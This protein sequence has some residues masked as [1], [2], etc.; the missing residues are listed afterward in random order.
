MYVCVFMYVYVLVCMYVLC[1][2]MYVMCVCIYVYM[3]CITYVFKYVCMYAGMY[4]CMM[5]VCMYAGMYVCI[6]ICCEF[7]GMASIAPPYHSNVRNY[8]FLY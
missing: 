5:Y 4:V 3:L 1:T 8:F 2:C 6:R 7:S